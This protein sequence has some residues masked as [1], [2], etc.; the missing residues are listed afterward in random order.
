MT[1]CAHLDRSFRGR[2]VP[3]QSFFESQSK[4]GCG[5]PQTSLG[6][7]RWSM[8]RS[9]SAK[10]PAS[11]TSNVTVPA[12]CSAGLRGLRL[13]DRGSVIAIEEEG[14]IA[15]RG[16]RQERAGYENVGAP[17]F[18]EGRASLP[19]RR[20]AWAMARRP[21]G[22]P[23]DNACQSGQPQGRPRALPVLVGAP[24]FSFCNDTKVVV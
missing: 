7:T 1:V 13:F 19:T 18:S 23:G 15:R 2:V 12:T 9:R 14:R 8:A 11:P 20:S 3:E 10:A 17:T 6:R 4:K 5:T 21:A 24:T 22:R 16:E